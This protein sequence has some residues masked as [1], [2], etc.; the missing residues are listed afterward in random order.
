MSKKWFLDLDF[1]PGK[2]NP[3][4]R[5]ERPFRGP[6]T[7]RDSAEH[8]AKRHAKLRKGD[9]TARVSSDNPFDVARTFSFKKKG[10]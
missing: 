8:Q 1:L 2:F 9:A 10:R 4:S 6:Y 5:A 3:A 7:T